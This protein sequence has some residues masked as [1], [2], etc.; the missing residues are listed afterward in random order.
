MKKA[1]LKPSI[2]ELRPTQFVLGM[3]EVEFKLSRIKR[4]NAKL[5]KAYIDDNVIPVIIG[6][7]KEMYI[8][9]HH[10]FARSCWEKGITSYKIGVIEDLS[11]LSEKKFWKVMIEKKWTYL[12]DQFGSGPHEPQDLPP[13]IAYMANDSYRSLAWALRH[14]GLIQKHSKPFFEFEWGA[15]FR[16]NLG[17]SLNQSSFE[18]ALVKARKLARSK[19][20]RKLPGYVANFS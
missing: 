6:P 1:V 4:M 11:G 20:A 13:N 2:L 15:F 5:M 10:H 8:I 17:F 7:K 18:K 14:E 12:M 9:D 16:L 3:M 19:R